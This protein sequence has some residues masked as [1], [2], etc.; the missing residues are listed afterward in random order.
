MIHSTGTDWPFYFPVERAL[1]ENILHA[2][3][4]TQFSTSDDGDPDPPLS[5]G[6]FKTFNLGSR[7]ASGVFWCFPVSVAAVEVVVVAGRQLKPRINMYIRRLISIEAYIKMILNKILNVRAHGALAR[8]R[9]ILPD[10]MM[11]C[12]TTTM[13]AVKTSLVARLAV[14]R[15]DS[16][17]A[18]KRHKLH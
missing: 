10:A 7:L 17:P 1:G 3:F 4:G 15:G 12:K 16:Q 13:P 14:R 6:E 9:K 5:G 18:I 8:P 11:V 2:S